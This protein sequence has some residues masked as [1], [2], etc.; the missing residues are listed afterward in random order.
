M[1]VAADAI[2]TR[3]EILPKH[4]EAS[5]RKTVLAAPPASHLHL[6]LPF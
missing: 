4:L 1:K 2:N 6:L 5:E 3:L